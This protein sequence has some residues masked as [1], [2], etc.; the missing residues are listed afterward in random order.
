MKHTRYLPERKHVSIRQMNNVTVSNALWPK[1][2][3][4]ITGKIRNSKK[5]DGQW[6]SRERKV[7]HEEEPPKAWG[8]K[9]VSTYILNM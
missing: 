3:I 4:F 9:L 5:T 2:T 8:A 6:I 1:S 7:N